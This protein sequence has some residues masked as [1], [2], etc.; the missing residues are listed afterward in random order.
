VITDQDK[1]AAR[2]VPLARLL[3]PDHKLIKKG[4]GKWMA[5]CTF[6]EETTPSMSLCQYPDGSW[7]YRCFGC[8]QT[9]DPI[10][11]VQAKQ[12]L[13]FQDAVKVLI[14]EANLAPDRPR[15]VAEY[16]YQDRDGKLLYQVVR[17]EPK[18]FR[19]RRPSDNGWQW[20]LDGLK[21]VL[22][23]FPQ[24]EAMPRTEPLFVVEG[25]KDV[26]MLISHGFWATTWAGGANAFNARLLDDITGKRRLVVV[27]DRDEPGMQVM[28]KVFGAARDRGHDV[29]FLL[30]DRGKDTTEFFELGGSKEHFLELVK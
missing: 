28:R 23:R 25:E 17:Y 5:L 15:I 29:G 18:G 6:H 19:V 24:L 16:D 9:G 2:R 21:R 4:P 26:H 13:D 11:Y 1:Q 8:G 14:K 7:G 30:L 20:C 22:Y 10:K 3:P 12:G 27:P